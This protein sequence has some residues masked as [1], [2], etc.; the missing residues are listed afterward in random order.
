MLTDTPFFGGSFADLRE[1]RN[2]TLLPTLRKDFI[3]DPYQVGESVLR[4]ADAIL[5]IVAALTGEE[6]RSLHAAAVEARLEVLVEVHDR[7]ELDRALDA[8]ARIVGVNNRDLRTMQVDLGTSLELANAIPD[9]VVAV[10]ESGIATADDVARLRDAGF[11]AFLVGEH[12][13]A[14]DDPAT[15][16]DALLREAAA[17]SRRSRVA[18][19]ICGITSVED[20]RSAAAAG[21]DAIGLVLSPAQRTGGGPRHR[22]RH[23]RRAAAVRPSGRGLRRSDPRRGGAARSRRSASTSSSCTGRAAGRLFRAITASR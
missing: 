20:A 4:G 21:A 6:L 8:G 23:R 7:R 3:V 18:V 19:K 14:Q 5:L 2:A 17:R 15:A 12:L 1:A 10:S 16:L 13:M 11:D 9:H 22:A